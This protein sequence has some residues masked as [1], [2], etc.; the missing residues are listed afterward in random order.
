MNEIYS[1]EEYLMRKTI[2]LMYLEKGKMVFWM[3]WLTLKSHWASDRHVLFVFEYVKIKQKSFWWIVSIGWKENFTLK[4]IISVCSI[5]LHQNIHIDQIQ[6]EKNS[7]DS[8]NDEKFPQYNI[9]LRYCDD[10]TVKNTALK[11][12][13]ESD[14]SHIQTKHAK[15]GFLNVCAFLVK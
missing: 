15:K 10:V 1:L 13:E 11:V 6:Y 12:E 9:V 14:F 4:R 7:A 3:G 8:M 5:N 2:F